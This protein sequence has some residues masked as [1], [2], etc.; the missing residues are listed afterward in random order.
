MN[1]KIFSYGSYK[2][3]DYI[4]SLQNT[5][6]MIILGRHESQGF[7]IEEELSFNVPLLVWSSTLRKQEYPYKKE[8]M[9][10]KSKVT[11]IPYWDERCGEFFHNFEELESTFDTFISKLE[12]YKP[13]DYI[14]ENLSVEKCSERFLQLIE[15][16]KENN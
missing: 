6:Y 10:V 7:A 4:S 14:L 12:T 9:N 3:E 16:A 11:T 8:Y 15:K 1:P 13:R 2:E 5:K